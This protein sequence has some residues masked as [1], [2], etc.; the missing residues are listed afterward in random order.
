MVKSNKTSEFQVIGLSYLSYI[1]LGLPGG[2]L[3]VAWPSIRET[4]GI[5][6]D[7]VGI[8]LAASTIGYLLSSF[9]SGRVIARLGTGLTL[10]LSSLVAAIGLLSYGLAPSWWFMVLIGLGGGLGT[11]TIDAGLNLYFA[12]VY[13]PRLM[14]WLHA[15]FGLGAAIGPLLITALLNS[16]LSWRIGYVIVGT[17]QLIMAASFA[18]TIRRWQNFGASTDT[19]ENPHVD[20]VPLA[21]TI[22]QPLVWLSILLFVF[23]AGIELAI[24]QWVYTFFTQARGVD[25]NTAGQWVSIYWASFTAGRVVFG[26]IANRL[27]IS[28]AITACMLITV[29]GSLLMWANLGDAASLI[30]LAAA[31]FVIG[32]IF[33]LLISTTPDRVGKHANNAVGI[34]VSAA[35]LGIAALPALAGVLAERIGIDSIAPFIVVVAVITLVLYHLASV[36]QISPLAKTEPALAD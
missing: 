8:L 16:Q 1:A 3:G 28:R 36:R 7:A 21:D 18:L 29:V 23:A 30:G 2:I 20:D 17:L 15:A 22:R 14:N 13:G 12:R 34:Q 24:G 9:F 27:P 32:P 6:L 33:P 10:A 25:L 4:F 11:G 5:S 31:G 19:S 35:S 26:I